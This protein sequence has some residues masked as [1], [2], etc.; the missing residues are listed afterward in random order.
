MREEQEARKRL[1]CL[2]AKARAM[3]EAISRVTD[4]FV[5]D[6]LEGQL[7][8]PVFDAFPDRSDLVRLRNDLI[9]ADCDLAK[10]IDQRSAMEK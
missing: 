3:T 8:D 5:H 10:K 6:T 9:D 7:T 4:N 2:K 1:E